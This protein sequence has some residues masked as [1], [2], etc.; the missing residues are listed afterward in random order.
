MDADIYRLNRRNFRRIKIPSRSASNSKL[1]RGWMSIK[2]IFG[3]PLISYGRGWSETT[4]QVG[5]RTEIQSLR[6]N[7]N[8]P[9]KRIEEE[10]P[11]KSSSWKITLLTIF[12]LI[13]ILRRC[14]AESFPHKALPFCER[15]VILHWIFF[16]I[17]V[18]TNA[19]GSV[20]LPHNQDLHFCTILIS[21]P[22]L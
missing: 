9:E 22:P 18:E 20:N 4:H 13:S 7:E 21:P 11:S 2:A 5:W 6:N 8:G 15:A 3:P 10:F 12:P 14:D 17:F 1:Q 16:R 19:W